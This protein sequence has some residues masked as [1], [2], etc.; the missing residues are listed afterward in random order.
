MFIPEALAI[1]ALFI[2]W[3]VAPASWDSCPATSAALNGH[4]AVS[5]E[6]TRQQVIVINCFE[7]SLNQGGKCSCKHSFS[8]N[9][10][11]Y[12]ERGE[13]RASIFFPIH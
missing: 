1:A 13:K 6:K 5:L 9:F 4:F 3:S 11:F 12:F 2:V 8:A 10:M 7:G